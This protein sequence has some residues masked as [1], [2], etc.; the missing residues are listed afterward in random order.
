MPCAARFDCRSMPRFISLSLIANVA[1][2]VALSTNGFGQT[3]VK[4]NQSP[5]HW[6]WCRNTGGDAGSSPRESNRC[7]LESRVE[8]AAP[9]QSAKLRL[10]ADFC[11]A[12]VEINGRAVVSVEPY[13]STADLEIDQAVRHG[14]N[15]ITISAREIDGPAAVAL[16][17]LITTSDG[18]RSEILTD[19]EWRVTD[20]GTGTGKAVSLGIVE[21]SF[22][23]I[24]RRPATIDPFDNYEQWRQA[25]GMQAKADQAAFWTASGFSIAL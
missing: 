22:W 19:G 9:P 11:H 4:P 12:R 8:L 1:L 25:I 6:I 17:L 21:P 18:R 24:N 13:S 3:L 23:G 15:R 16:S 5:P 2:V 20:V 10:A 14:E 7:R